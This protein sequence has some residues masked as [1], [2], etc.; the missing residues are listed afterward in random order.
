MAKFKFSLRAARPVTV[1]ATDGNLYKLKSGKN[2]FE[3][4]YSAYVSLVTAL[5][6]KPK[7]ECSQVHPESV[8][9]PNSKT[10]VEPVKELENPA[11]E[12]KSKDNS[13]SEKEP[14]STEDVKEQEPTA[15]EQEPTAHEHESTT[16]EKEHEST[17]ELESETK[18]D[19][20]LEKFD[21][22][23]MSYT[24]LKTEYK[25]IT[26]KPCKLKK[27]ELIKFLQEQENA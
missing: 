11:K 10:E 27:E 5:G 13:S 22:S 3:L 16:S 20:S 26:G 23:N 1:R 15:T 24:K 8:E 4:E 18:S 19:E 2:E 7:P 9:K 14:E 12:D 25:R 6:I 21:Y 17:E